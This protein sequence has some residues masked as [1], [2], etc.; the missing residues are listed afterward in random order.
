MFTHGMRRFAGCTV[1]LMLA[2]SAARAEKIYWADRNNSRIQRS[3]LDGT[4]VET[5]VSTGLLFPRGLAL[6]VAAG[7]LYFSDEG[8]NGIQRSNLDGSGA[9]LVLVGSIGE[10]WGVAFDAAGGKL[11]WA[12]AGTRKISRCNLDGTQVEHILEEPVE[13]AHG[14]AIH[15]AAGK[16]YWTDRL[17]QNISRSNLDGSNIETLIGSLSGP[18]GIALDTAAG[19]MYWAERTSQRIRR[20]NLDGTGSE[21]L[22]PAP[23]AGGA[24]GI[25]LDL[26]AGKIYWT[27]PNGLAIRRCNLDGT[28]VETVFSETPGGR[29]LPGPEGIYLDLVGGKMY[30]CDHGLQTIRR[31]N[32]NGTSL[33]ELDP[34]A[35]GDAKGIYVDTVAG[36]I[37]WSEI[38]VNHGGKLRSSDLNG[39]GAVDLVTTELVQPV[40]LAIDS[41]AGKLYWSDLYTFKIQRSNLDGSNVEDLF[42]N[43]GG[44]RG[45]ALDLQNNKLYWTDINN[46]RVIRGNLNGT[47]LEV[48]ISTGLNGPNS[49]AL[50][51]LGG[52]MYWTD[53]FAGK[54]QRANLN[55]SNVVDLIVGGFGNHKGV[56][57]DLSAG[58]MYWADRT[59]GTIVR[60]NLDGTGVQSIVT[61]L[62]RPETT[63]LELISFSQQPASQVLCETDPLA[64]SV[65]AVGAP[66][67]SYQWRKNGIDIPSATNSTYNIP[68]TVPGDTGDYDCVVT[69]ANSQAISNDAVVVVAVQPSVTGHPMTQTVCE[70]DATV[71]SV[72]ASGAALDYQWRVDGQDIPGE[73]GPTITLDPVMLSD[74][75]DYDVVVTNNCGTAI[76][77]VATLT[78]EELPAVTADP[79]PVVVCEDD[80]AMFSV[81]TTGSAPMSYQWRRNGMDVPGATGDTLV[82]DPADPNDAGDYDVVVTNGCGQE[83]SSPA[84]LTVEIPVTVATP[85]AAQS[86][87]E[88]G[89]VMFT[90][91][92]A[93]TPPFTYQW[94][95]EGADIPGETGDTL[96]LDPVLLT[97]AGNYDVVI[98]NNCGQ[99]IST[100]AALS[101]D[102]LATI[103]VQPAPQT[104]CEAESVEFSVTASGAATLTYQWRKDGIDIPGETGASLSIDPVDGSDAGSYDVVVSNGCNSVI[105]NAANFDVEFLPFILNQPINQSACPDELVTFSVTAD[106]T[107][108]L[109]YQWRRNGQ[110]IPGAT[111][112]QLSIFVTGSLLRG[113]DAY[114][115]VIT[116]GCGQVIS[117]PATL[118]IGEP[119]VVTTPPA[120]QSVC[121]AGALTLNVAASGSG[122]FTYQWRK[123]GGDL[124]GESN[125]SLTI[126]PVVPGDAG[127]YD[128]IITNGCGQTTS[129][130]AAVTI[131][132]G[133][134]IGTQPVSQSVCEGG[135]VTFSVSATGSAPV[136]YQWRNGGVD[137]PGATGAS[138]NINPVQIS[139]AGSYDVVVTDACDQETSVAATLTV[140]AA[141]SVTTPPT[142]QSVC[143]GGSVTLTVVGAGEPPLMYQWRKGGVDVPGATSDSLTINPAGLADAGSYDVV[144]SNGCSQVTSAAATITVEEG[145]SID[146]QPVSD[147]A[148]DGGSAA[149]SVTASGRGPISYQWRFGGADLPGET[150]DT[151]LID[152]VSPGDAGSYD[153]VVTNACGQTISAAA[154]LTL[155]DGPGIDTPPVSQ[156]ICNGGSVTFSVVATGTPPLTYQWRKGGADL[157]G[158]TGA[159]LNINPAIP[160]DAGDYDVVVTNGCG[161][162]ISA[163]ATLTV[164]ASA[165]I[166]Q[167]PAALSVCSGSPANFSV[168]A[169]GTAPITYQWRKG[170][171]DIGGATSDTLSIPSASPADAGNYDVV[172]TTGCGQ[173]ISAAAALT[174]DV[175]PTISVHPQPQTVCDAGQAVF[176]VTAAGTGPFTYQWRRDGVNIPG[177]TQDTLVIFVI[178][179]Q[180]RTVLGNYDVVVTN[181]CGSIISDSA[182]LT[183]NQS[184]NITLQPEGTTACEQ[185]S[186]SLTVG[187]SGTGPF[188]YQWRKGGLELGGA[189]T[190]TLSFDPLTP[191]DAGSYDVIVTN[192]CGQVTS[193]VAVIVVN[194]GPALT[195]APQHVEKCA[196]SN[197]VFTIGATGAGTLHYQ[198]Y[199]DGV[200]TGTDSSTL[201]LTNVSLLDDGAAVFCEVTDDCDTLVSPTAD[202]LVGP[203]TA[204]FDCDA[205]VDLQDF[206]VFSLCFS[207]T[208]L[209]PA[210]SCPPG[211]DADF[212]DDGD[213]DTA[214]FAMLAMLFTGA[215]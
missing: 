72:T 123:D 73:T 54:L 116:N 36:V 147:S 193:A 29:P 155:E 52:L 106:G 153:V 169:A 179:S 92:P 154:T 192:A 195:Q 39:F 69:N 126:D 139:S 203:A 31:A 144:I 178:E 33:E 135:N 136:T 56:S 119:P 26:M 189:M 196:G 38:D 159:S 164:N 13:E 22:V 157:P 166:S 117:V 160:T 50:D 34:S 165:S 130:A 5:I 12:D 201:T 146:T 185:D 215:R 77:N 109:T 171:V 20:A 7:K 132:E 122:P 206:A 152:P 105:S 80:A 102:A 64:L 107:A 86:I 124:P 24:T 173:V 162:T 27:D 79:Q 18:R 140:Q 180:L 25:A 37:Y 30:W 188:S 181:G 111:G 156:S 14:I 127:N 115:V 46:G 209:P 49:I 112:N 11:Y 118:T 168:V 182:T 48:L 213:V 67:L 55:G 137:I 93:G 142:S 66:P 76:S 35:A 45:I 100:A 143:L 177:A 91:T 6:D 51:T 10:P 202:L 114:D 71:L 138:L 28:S 208:M 60:A 63:A 19:K 87:C 75:G 186:I 58:K 16:M 212:D 59:L 172:V 175:A 9:E 121:D 184:P 197:A 167:Q 47:V 88:L 57:L 94:R 129:P 210:A 151:L 42:L 163:I 85:P 81:S 8:T 214:D 174:V 40:D 125:A 199:V 4:S 170:G 101:V 23:T 98:T 148:C 61:G 145:P 198:W 44:C 99:V 96:T 191:E 120:S 82:I 103:D 104:V 53:P 190:E 62:G 78:V 68:S 204:N 183:H 97:D 1:A 200:P 141:P 21:T 158:A 108:P 90:V 194:T 128:V 187:V 84:T 41:A 15:A 113:A 3:N 74:A 17:Q 110:D 89:S 161:Q 131:A 43:Q 2:G 95:F 150:N 211:A 70:Q 134:S 65:V 207:G 149:F 133:P 83:I 176:N 205:D 32:F